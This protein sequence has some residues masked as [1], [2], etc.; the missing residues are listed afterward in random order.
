[1]KN[2]TWNF[3]LDTRPIHTLMSLSGLRSQCKTRQFMDDGSYID[4]NTGADSMKAESAWITRLKDY[5]GNH[6]ESLFFL[7][8]LSCKDKTRSEILDR[9]LLEPES[10]KALREQIY[11]I[12]K[13]CDLSLIPLFF[14]EK[15]ESN[16]NVSVYI[17][18]SLPLPDGYVEEVIYNSIYPLC[19][20]GGFFR[21]EYG[22]YPRSIK[23]ALSDT[24]I[25]I[26]DGILIH[27]TEYPWFQKK[28]E[29]IG[30]IQSAASLF[31]M[32]ITVLFVNELVKL[33]LGWLLFGILIASGIFLFI[34]SRRNSQN[35][36]SS[37]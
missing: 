30:N 23:T 20:A 19:E 2:Y 12:F 16:G 31:I 9:S 18:L 6:P 13:K 32:I 1:M 4:I 8:E 11:S 37:N 36:D 10:F 25:N 28:F 15:T 21:H 35:A 22:L 34:R 29:Y 17:L 26:H 14:I 3:D 33:P 7:S 5:S 27:E 24:S